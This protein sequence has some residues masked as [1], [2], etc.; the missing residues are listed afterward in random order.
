MLGHEVFFEGDGVSQGLPAGEV[1]E[2]GQGGIR[3]RVALPV[4]PAR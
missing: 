4:V 1:E 3:G 2:V